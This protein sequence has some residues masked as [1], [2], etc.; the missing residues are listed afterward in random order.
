ML[1]CYNNVQC[2]ILCDDGGLKSSKLRSGVDSQ[3]VGQHCPC[4]LISAKSVTL[5][6]G[7]VEGEHE[8]PPSPLAQRC[9]RHRRLELADDLRGAGRREQCVGSILDK[10]GVTLNP[11]CLFRCSPPTI[12]QFG[13]TSP[14]GQRL[15]EASH[16]LAD[17]AG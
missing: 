16:R 5:P 11:S 2:H 1:L 6:A 7:A 14:E 9:L 13:D 10:R 12:G 15:L 8:L 17:V 4:P 3:L